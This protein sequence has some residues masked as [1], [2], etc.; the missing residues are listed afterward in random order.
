MKYNFFVLQ[1][2]FE[3]TD[4]IYFSLWILKKIIKNYSKGNLYTV[5]L[6]SLIELINPKVV[7]N[8]IDNSLKFSENSKILEKKN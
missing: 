8:T 1:T 7:I 2:R 4:K 6:I 3:F 5:Y